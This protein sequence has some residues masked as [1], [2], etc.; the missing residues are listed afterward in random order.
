MSAC[1]T[2]EKLV[3][4][5]ENVRD[6]LLRIKECYE[7][8]ASIVPLTTCVVSVVKN[9]GKL[10]L[11]M[12]T[13]L[14]FRENIRYVAEIIR[15]RLK[16]DARVENGCVLVNLDASGAVYSTHE[17]FRPPVMCRCVKYAIDAIEELINIVKESLKDVVAGESRMYPLV[18]VYI[19]AAANLH[20]LVNVKVKRKPELKKLPSIN[21]I[22][23]GDELTI[24]CTIT[25]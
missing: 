11:T 9:S 24:D 21:Y 13:A 12:C 10:Q 2:F 4:T 16:L 1:G 23:V 6:T 25:C 3:K 19:D 22:V 15:D 8:A 14:M 5:L 17:G 20:I 7:K 18:E